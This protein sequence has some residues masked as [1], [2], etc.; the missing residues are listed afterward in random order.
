MGILSGLV[1]AAVPAVGGY[2]QGRNAQEA[3]AYRRSQIERDREDKLKHQAML[4]ALEQ[5][6][7]DA[8]QK[9]VGVTNKRN[10]RLDERVPTQVVDRLG[11]DGKPR[12]YQIPEFGGE[13]MDTGL[14]PIPEPQGGGSGG[15]LGSGARLV[16][17][18]R[19]GEMV[20]VS[21]GAPGV[22]VPA[23]VDAPTPPAVNADITANERSLSKVNEAL[24]AVRAN[25]DAFGGLAQWAL[26]GAVQGVV[27]PK[28]Q[29][30]RNPVSDI[31]SLE[32]KDRS[33]ATVP[34]AEMQRL[35]FI[36]NDRDPPQVIID[37]LTRMRDWLKTEQGI[38][39]Q[40]YPKA[41]GRSGG[42]GGSK[43]DRWEDLVASGMSKEEATAMVNEEFGQ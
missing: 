9:Q 2:L 30:F 43:A 35:G 39:I 23:G 3:E 16:Q 27:D 17:D 37:K 10:M 5:A 26:P 13:P 12:T 18:P 15:G 42:A 7:F 22:R 1:R 24:A 6:Q 40:Q 8:Q 31:G 29:K 36:P 32:I 41:R 14:R 11:P 20:W 34:K 4:M 33:G 38:L 28:G 25:P 19:T 21:P